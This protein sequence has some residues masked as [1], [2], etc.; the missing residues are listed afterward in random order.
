MLFHYTK[1]SNLKSIISSCEL[2][3]TNISEF[4]DTS[5]YIYTVDLLCREMSLPDNSVSEILELIQNE[6]K[7]YYVCCFCADENNLH[8]WEN[9]GNV[10]ISFEETEL[11][12]MIKSNQLNRL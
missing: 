2:W 3:F 9:Y 5:E 7:R 4:N 10:R 11:M 6:M 12:S 8:L 1:T